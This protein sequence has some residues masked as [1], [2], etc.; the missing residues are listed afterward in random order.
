MTTQP[1]GD[2]AE[3][4]NGGVRRLTRPRAETGAAATTSASASR[5]PRRLP[6]PRRCRTGNARR[7]RPGIY[8]R[9]PRAPRPAPPGRAFPARR[10]WRKL[11]ILVPAGEDQI[12]GVSALDDDRNA[13]RRAHQDWLHHHQQGSSGDDL[14]HPRRHADLAVHH[15]TCAE[16]ITFILAFV[17]RS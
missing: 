17:S 6:V 3:T 14:R 16:L 5:R 11:S 13:S 4:G 12:H 15:P 9:P 1:A 10:Q 2:I 7:S 8:P